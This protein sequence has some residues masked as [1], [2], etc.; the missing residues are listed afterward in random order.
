[1][2][3]TKR[4]AVLLSGAAILLQLSC[5]KEKNGS[6]ISG[7]LLKNMDTLV[8]PGDNFDAYVNGNWVKNNQI[9]ADKSSYGV[10]EIID[11]EAI[12]NVQTIITDA[13]KGHFPEGSKEQKMGDFYESYLDFKT[14]DAKGIT[15]LA[16][17]MKAI[18]AIKNDDDLA[19]YFGKSMQKVQTPVVLFVEPD[20][21]NPSKYAL[22]AWQSGLGLP[23]REYYLHS[24]ATSASIRKQYQIHISNML[25][26]GGVENPEAGAQKIMG[27]ETLLASKQMKKEDAR[28]N[29]LTYN[30]YKIADAAKLLPSFNL[31]KMLENSGVKNTDEIIIAQV[32]YLKALDNIIKTT[33]IDTLEIVLQMGIAALKI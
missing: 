16:E 5:A 13:A 28:D 9:P 18:D 29:Q 17:E 32:D 10:S 33:S 24:D 8:K 31:N 19:V 12:K 22:F 26:L 20:Y 25:K 15:P 7:L 30:K 11:D 27:L 4:I 23:E 6:Q 14:R 2:K 21:K 1:M 3:L